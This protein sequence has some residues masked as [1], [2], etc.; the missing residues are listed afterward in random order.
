VIYGP[1]SALYPGNSYG[2]VVT[3]TTRMPDKFEFHAA[4]KGFDQQFNLYETDQWYPGW[5][6][7]LAVGDRFND[8]SVWFTYDHVTTHSQPLQFANLLPTSGAFGPVPT[9]GG[10]SWLSPIGQAGL[11]AGAN[12]IYTQDQG[13]YKLK[14]AYDFTTTTRLTYTGAFFDFNQN[15]G[16][17]SYI[18]NSAGA[19]IYNSPTGAITNGGQ[20]YYLFGED[21]EHQVDRRLMEGLELKSDSH[22]LFDYDLVVSH[23]LMLDN[24]TQQSTNYGID[25]TGQDWNQ[26]GTGWI[27][28]DARGIWRPDQ[29]VLGTHEVS[30]CGHFDQYMLRQSFS[31]GPEWTSMVGMVPYAE[32]SGDT[33]TKAFY[34]QDAWTFLPEWK[35][36]LGGREEFWS[37]HRDE[38]H[39]RRSGFP[40]GRTKRRPE[41]QEFRSTGGL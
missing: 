12:N 26:N 41:R 1:F 31:Y 25:N 32:T 6:G 16:V 29:N 4:L 2:G 8:L 11:I 14:I 39:V 35:L 10:S 18:Y 33:Q 20:Q 17:Q 23:L 37:Q 30:F 22:G 3:F 13:L 7:S 24:V 40:S 28:A 27:T 36:V 19:P 21:P 34:L 38:R 15:S 5:N 9:Y